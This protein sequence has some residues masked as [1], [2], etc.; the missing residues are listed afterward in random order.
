MNDYE[1]LENLK[2]I[3]VILECV[4]DDTEFVLPLNIDMTIQELISKYTPVPPVGEH[5]NY[6]CPVCGRR[7]RSGK[8]SSSFVQ[9]KRCQ[10]CGQLFEW[11]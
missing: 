2:D 10:N 4:S 3:R 9:D 11:D 1:I 8:G 7:V 5:T 6:K